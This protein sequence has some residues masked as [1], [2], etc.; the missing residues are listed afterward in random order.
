MLRLKPLLPDPSRSAKFM[1]I[2]KE[3]DSAVLKE[4]LEKCK[5]SLLFF[6]GCEDDVVL[7][8][9][10]VGVVRV[11]F[12]PIFK[13][14][15]ETF[16]VFENESEAKGAGNIFKRGIYV[17]PRFKDCESRSNAVREFLLD[18]KSKGRVDALKGWRNEVR[19][20]A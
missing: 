4:S 18:L 12:I 1:N 5:G 16:F 7:N 3:C 9:T 20:K 17:N 19:L 6:V 8:D 14:Y 2:A 13:E 11:D 10:P 15:K